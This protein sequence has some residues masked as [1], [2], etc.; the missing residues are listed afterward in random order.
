MLRAALKKSWRQHP[1]RQRLYGHLPFISQTI[2]VRRTRHARHCWRRKD[3]LISDTLKWTLVHDCASD[4]RP[5][6]PYIGSTRTSFFLI[7]F[8]QAHSSQQCFTLPD[9]PRFSNLLAVLTKKKS[10]IKEMLIFFS[11]S[12]LHKKRKKTKQSKKVSWLK[13]YLKNKE[14][15]RHF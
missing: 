9:S 1:T 10:T 13:L 7:S 4:S 5:S 3:E 11:K 15:C 8:K 12:E 2:Q 6:K 14:L